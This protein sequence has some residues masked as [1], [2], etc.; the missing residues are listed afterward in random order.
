MIGEWEAG[1]YSFAYTIFSIINVTANSLDN[2]WGPWFYEKMKEKDYDGIRRYSSKYAFGML[3]FSILVMLGAP[4]LVKILGTKD[5]YDAMYSVV[6]IVAGG[7]Y[8]FLYLFP[9]YVE[10]YYEKTKY[11]ALGTGLAAVI[12]V[13]LNVVCIAKFGYLAAA[14]TTMATYLLY[15]TFHY[16]I[17]WRI[18]KGSLFDTGKLIQYIL[19]AFAFSLVA[20]A[21]MEHWLIRWILIIGLGIYF[22]FWLEREFALRQKIRKKLGK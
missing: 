3:L 6:P 2:V 19:L 8:M 12:N 16:M 10:Y 17:A 1:I 20:L 13:V 18:R 5:Y 9:S 15:F 4:E 7:Y 21:L 14:Y 11:I 22:L